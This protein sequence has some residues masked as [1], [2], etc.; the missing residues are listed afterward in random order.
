MA[1]LFNAVPF[2]DRGYTY[3]SP[4]PDECHKMGWHI[5]QIPPVPSN[6]QYNT[7]CRTWIKDTI[8]WQDY[9]I[10]T[11]G[12]VYFGPSG[13]GLCR[14][15]RDPYAAPHGRQC[16]PHRFDCVCS[17]ANRRQYLERHSYGIPHI[18]ELGLLK[19]I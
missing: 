3:K 5:G 15:R 6:M 18:L 7:P 16:S 8:W 10:G 2:K 9:V 4:T 13:S 14:H 17:P 11:Y 1:Q 12:T 19:L